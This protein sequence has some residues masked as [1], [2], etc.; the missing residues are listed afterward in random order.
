MDTHSIDTQADRQRT[1]T[2]LTGRPTDRGLTHR[3][4]TQEPTVLTHGQTDA[5][6]LDTDNNVK[7]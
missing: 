2:G 4:G 6:N 3:L 7:Q 1:N 5:E